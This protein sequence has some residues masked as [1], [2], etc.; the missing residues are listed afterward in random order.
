MVLS[1]PLPKGLEACD[2]KIS[3]ADKVLD[4][5]EGGFDGVYEVNGCHDGR[6]LYQRK[7]KKPSMS[8]DGSIF[9]FG[10]ACRPPAT[11]LLPRPGPVSE[12]QHPVIC[13][14][15]PLVLCLVQGLGLQ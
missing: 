14:A 3:G 4:K 12:L 11:A 8:H 15:P 2:I 6:P 1:S 13:R 7:G 9:L 10:V 5:L